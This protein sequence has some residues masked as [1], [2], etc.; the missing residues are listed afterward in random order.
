MS[1]MMSCGWCFL[2]LVTA[3]AAICN[4]YDTI[5]TCGA[6]PECAWSHWGC[7]SKDLGSAEAI[8][9]NWSWKGRTCHEVMGA[10]WKNSVWTYANG[11]C[12]EK[13]YCPESG[14]VSLV[15]SW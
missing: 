5:A 6:H 3:C 11:E 8:P 13:S 1:S 12:S 15:Q 2:L 14:K 7:V 9:G 10:D 4:D